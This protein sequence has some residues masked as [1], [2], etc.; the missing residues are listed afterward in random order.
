MRKRDRTA[1]IVNG[2]RQDEA[3]APALLMSPGL[4]PLPPGSL[5]FGADVPGL[6]PLPAG[7]LGFGTESL[8]GELV[9]A[10]VLKGSQESVPCR[11]PLRRRRW[12]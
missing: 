11:L 2:Q 1:Q 4:H 9:P 6:H 3:M 5:G 8:G 7:C 12:W 10:P